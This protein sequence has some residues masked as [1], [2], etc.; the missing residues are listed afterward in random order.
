MINARAARIGTAA[1]MLTAASS[2]WAARPLATE[3]NGTNAAGQCQV[4]SWVDNDRDGRHGHIAPAC[5]LMPGLEL[6]LDFVGGKPS[7]AVPISRSAALRW[8]PDWMNWQGWQFGVKGGL[9]QEK[10]IETGRWRDATPNFTMVASHELDASWTVFVNMGHYHSQPDVPAATVAAVALTW[11]PD[12]RWLVF[13]ELLG[14]HQAPATQQVGMRWW[15]WPDKLGLDFTAG[16]ANATRDSRSWGVG[17]G[18]YGLS[19]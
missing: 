8:A 1:L 17:L 10:A 18:W 16:R 12:A 3:D 11:A 9:A 15:L 19:F 2:V 14:Q 6:A 13:A 4:E 7:S 5:G